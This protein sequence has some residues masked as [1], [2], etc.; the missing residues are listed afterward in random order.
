[1][2]ATTG[3]SDLN[4]LLCVVIHD[5]TVVAIEWRPFGPDEFLC[6]VYHDLPV[7]A[8]KSRSFGPYNFFAL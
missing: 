8:I 7:V 4:N 6:G 1:M 5:L 3:P 2:K